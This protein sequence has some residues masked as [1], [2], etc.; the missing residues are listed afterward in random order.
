MGAE[1]AAEI[2]KRNSGPGMLLVRLRP[3]K[4]LAAFNLT[5]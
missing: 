3:T 4:V 1:A 5:G 2:G